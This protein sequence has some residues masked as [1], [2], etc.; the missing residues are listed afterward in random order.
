METTRGLWF[1]LQGRSR[2]LYKNAIAFW[3][4]GDRTLLKTDTDDILKGGALS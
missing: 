2:L 3:L 4:L 1:E